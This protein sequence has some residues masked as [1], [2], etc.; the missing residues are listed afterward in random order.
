MIVLGP[1]H[2]HALPCPARR[3]L[4]LFPRRSVNIQA[5]GGETLVK[6][7]DGEDYITSYFKKDNTTTERI[8]PIAGVLFIDGQEG[9]D[10]IDIYLSGGATVC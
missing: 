9:D 4:V 5:T 3:S 6:G 8:N 2:A 1:S 10:Y 7:G